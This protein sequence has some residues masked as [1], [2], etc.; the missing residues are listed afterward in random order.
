MGRAASAAALGAL[1]LSAIRANPPAF[2]LIYQ[3]G[4]NTDG[5]TANPARY[6]FT[7]REVYERDR[8]QAELNNFDQKGPIYWDHNFK[9]SFA[10][11]PDIPARRMTL[12]WRP[13]VDTSGVT[14]DLLKLL[15]SSI[16]WLLDGKKNAKIVVNPNVAAIGSLGD[17]LTAAGHTL[18]DDD[19]AGTPDEQDVVGDLF[20]HGP[21][22]NNASR[23]V[24]S[25]KPVLVLN[26]PDWDDML[27]GS[28]GS[29]A[30]FAPGKVTI[31]AAGHAAAGGKTGTF[32][33]FT[34]DHAFELVGSFL[35]PEATVLATVTRII[36]PAINNLGDVD[37]S[38][39]GTKVHTK[40]TGTV[41]EVDFSD[42][43]AGGWTFDNAV[44]GGYTGNWGL[45]VKGKLAVGTAG[46]Y[47]F[48]LGSDDGAQL[49]IDADKNGLTSADSVLLDQGP[50][51][52]QVV[53][54]NVTFATAG[55]YDFEVRAYNSGGAGSLELSVATQAGEIPDDALDSG[56]WEALSTT[57]ASPVKLQAAA[58]V[59]GFKAS[60]P[61]VEVQTPLIILHNGPADSPKG[62]FFDGG[63]I[64]GQ[65]GVGFIGGAG[66]NKWTYPEGQNYRSVRLKPVNVAGKKNV[67]VTVALAGTVVD[68]E[69][70]DFIDVVVYPKGESSTPVTLAHFRGV[71]NAIQP[72]LADEKEKFVR[73][74]TRTFADFIYDVP[75]D[76]TDLVV[77]IR[78]ATSW[79]TEIVA[80]DNIRITS[81]IAVVTEPIKITSVARDGDS[82][83]LAWTGGATGN[84]KVQ[85]RSS[86]NSGAW[87]DVATVTERSAKVALSGPAQFLRVVQ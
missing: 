71:Q 40:E 19:T 79:W 77:E 22:A 43:S 50:H 58:T 67:K 14:D 51:G 73:K 66:L 41:T 53:Y 36:P 56:Y 18:V 4:F 8:T 84:F 76:A 74:L 70:S 37:A 9:V 17:R 54:A 81:G 32:D 83:A 34:G 49:L 52:H 69:D 57:G 16:G 46:T 7:G 42:A 27:V 29:A 75:A 44:P 68:F 78:A 59:T 12:T 13:A 23:F 1:A 26:N 35:P 6:S 30:T 80:I 72:W 10:G 24:L 64:N 15:D 38:I 63:P 25:P 48:A 45:Q 31:A 21:G 65:E 39:A 55:A 62:K 11:N 47:R 87:T 2:E 60:G 85:G 20:V 33:A 5:T 86:V 61:D 3:E 28:I 82:V